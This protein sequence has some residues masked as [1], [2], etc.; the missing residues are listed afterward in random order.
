MALG[1][2]LAVEAPLYVLD[3]PDGAIDA[4]HRQIVVDALLDTHARTGATMLIVTHDIDLARSVADRIA[5]LTRGL[6]VFQ[7]DPDEALPRLR[8]W[9]AQ[10]DVPLKRLIP[11][12]RRSIDSIPT[13]IE[14]VP[15]AA[16]T[17]SAV[18]GALASALLMA[19]FVAMWVAMALVV[20]Y[21][22]PR[23]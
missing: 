16:P 21:V 8:G 22:V 1:A 5:V 6:I 7:G 12:A 18:P 17:G 19:V 3:D 2:T 4:V 14:R 20:V 23:G 11:L 9:Y 15:R 10:E 13:G